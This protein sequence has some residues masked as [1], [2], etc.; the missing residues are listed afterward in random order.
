[1]IF[2]DIIINHIKRYIHWLFEKS[3]RREVIGLHSGMFTNWYTYW[4]IE[5]SLRREFLGLSFGM[6]NNLN[7]FMNL[8]AKYNFIHVKIEVAF[9]SLKQKS[10]YMV[11]F[12]FWR[13]YHFSNMPT[14]L[15]THVASQ[16]I[17]F[18]VCLMVSL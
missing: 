13:C 14:P 3:L 7:T 4:L 16:Q 1:M 2:P 15:E 5:P 8:E 6:F 17:T 10:L 12:I 11:Y 18:A 9:C